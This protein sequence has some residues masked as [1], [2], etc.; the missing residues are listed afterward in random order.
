MRSY[1]TIVIIA[2]LALLSALVVMSAGTSESNEP[3][4][5]HTGTAEETTLQNLEDMITNLEIRISSIEADIFGSS[6]FRGD[7]FSENSIEGWIINLDSRLADL[8]D[9]FKQ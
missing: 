5:T 9:T 3:E 1:I 6:A 4:Y 2:I 7:P 8:E